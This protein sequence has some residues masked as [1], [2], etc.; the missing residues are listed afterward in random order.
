MGIERGEG[1]KIEANR[2]PIK[3]PAEYEHHEFS[4]SNEFEF[5]IKVVYIFIEKG[6]HKSDERSVEFLLECGV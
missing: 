3:Y 4:K 6:G 5:N 2:F 1:I